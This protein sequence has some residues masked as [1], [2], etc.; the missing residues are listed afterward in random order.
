MFWVVEENK[1]VGMIWLWLRRERD[2]G[3][4]FIDGELVRWLFVSKS[5]CVW[6]GCRNVEWDIIV[7]VE[8]YN[9][10]FFENNFIYLFLFF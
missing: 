9:I 10:F 1:N 3:L 4:V 5:L 2:G 8:L 6:R 7:V